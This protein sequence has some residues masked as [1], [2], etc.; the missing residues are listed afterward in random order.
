M[1]WKILGWEKLYRERKDRE[2]QYLEEIPNILLP[3]EVRSANYIAIGG[4][5][6]GDLRYAGWVAIACYWASQTK[7]L[8]EGGFLWGSGGRAATIKDIANQRRLESDRSIKLAIPKLLK[9]GWLCKWQPGGNHVVTTRQPSG[10]ARKGKERKPKGSKEKKREGNEEGKPQT[11]KPEKDSSQLS[12]ASDS[13]HPDSFCLVM[14]TLI[15]EIT[16]RRGFYRTRI[17]EKADQTCFKKLREHIEKKC[18][19][20]TNAQLGHAVGML[21]SA[22]SAD[23]PMACF[24]RAAQD[25]WIG[26]KQ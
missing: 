12:F 8:R 26:W 24:M 22:E 11:Q 21:V 16:K 14:D 19:T 3:T 20:N 15:R 25:H 5:K 10:G 6:D 2:N 17:Q 1:G 9:I 23:K 7:R 4:G 13:V 18:P